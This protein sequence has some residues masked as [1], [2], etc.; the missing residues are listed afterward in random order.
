LKLRLERAAAKPEL[1]R[2]QLAVLRDLLATSADTVEALWPLQ[3][4]E[5]LDRYANEQHLYGLLG[6]D[7]RRGIA[8]HYF[9]AVRD[10]SSATQQATA[11][12][13]LAASAAAA[14]TSAAMCED[15]VRTLVLTV[16]EWGTTGDSSRRAVLHEVLRGVW[17]RLQLND[18]GCDWKRICT[19]PPYR[20]LLPFDDPGLA[21]V[22]KLV[23]QAVGSMLVE[24][25]AAAATAVVV[26][27]HLQSETPPVTTVAQVARTY[28]ELYERERHNPRSSDIIAVCE[29]VFAVER[30]ATSVAELTYQLLAQQLDAEL[31]RAHYARDANDALAHCAGLCQ[32]HIEA[33]YRLTMAA[34]V[35][36]TTFTELSYIVSHA[37]AC[38]SVEDTWHRI[39]MH[40]GLR[41][42]MEAMRYELEP[43][44]SRRQTICNSY[45]IT[46]P[47]FGDWDQ[48]WSIPRFRH[49]FDEVVYPRSFNLKADLEPSTAYRGEVGLELTAAYRQH[50]LAHV[51]D[52]VLAEGGDQAEARVDE[53]VGR[54]RFETAEAYRQHV[55]A[56]FRKAVQGREFAASATDP[57]VI[58]W[59]R[60][61]LLAEL[62][63]AVSS[64]PRP[65]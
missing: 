50:A 7:K 31:V 53:L 25:P 56:L 4:A 11:L 6:D 62:E 51:V 8:A 43:S 41:P 17:R 44:E 48:L 45:Q 59:G 18:P 40:Y 32:P 49:F 16:L 3:R 5:L 46:R 26:P 9:A 64:P 13:A 19:H 35:E 27:T 63:D 55:T 52:Y 34:L 54:R 28:H 42:I 33:H 30:A 15:A 2:H 37:D 38:F 57:G 60:P 1:H 58:Y 29:R 21:L 47:I 24:V 65:W 12:S 61:V 20:N 14:Y 22:G 39:L 23:N 36:A 10:A